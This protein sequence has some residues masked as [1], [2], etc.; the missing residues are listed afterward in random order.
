[1]RKGCFFFF[2]LLI[3]FFSF[4]VNGEL[5]VKSRTGHSC[6]PVEFPNTVMSRYLGGFF[7]TSDHAGFSENA[8]IGK[9]DLLRKLHQ[10]GR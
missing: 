8:K 6:L 3:S 2:F 10:K 7:R 1:M 5:G 9:L 4:G